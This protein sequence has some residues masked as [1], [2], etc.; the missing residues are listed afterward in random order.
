MSKI[1]KNNGNREARLA[2]SFMALFFWQNA[3][4]DFALNGEMATHDLELRI[5]VDQASPY[6]NWKEG[7]GAFGF[8]VDILTEAAR[9]VGI[10]LRWINCPE[11]PAKALASGKVDL[12]PL[13]AT[14]YGKRLGAYVPA[15]WLQ[16]EYA[17][18]WIRPL[19][20][21]LGQE[22]DWSNQTVSVLNMPQNRASARQYFHRSIFDYTPNRTVAMQHMCLGESAAAFMEIRIM[23]SLLLE[24]PKGCEALSLGVRVLPEIV[25]PMSLVATQPYRAQADVL[26]AQIGQ[27]FLNGRY[28]QLADKWFVF[29]NV[30]ARSMA[31]LL[32][33]R[34]RNR[35]V[36][37]ALGI[38]SIFLCLLLFAVRWA[39]RARHLAEQA[40]RAKSV[41]LANVSHEVRT[42]M[43]GVLG[44]CD[45]LLSTELTPLQR[46]FA[47]TI[48]ES[49]QLQLQ[50]LNDLLDSA[51]IEAG[52]VVLEAIPFSPQHLVEAISR[53]FQADVIKKGLRLTREFV[54][55]PPY[56]IGDPLRVRQIVNNLISN[57]VKF[58]KVG[59]IHIKLE[60]PDGHG[61]RGLTITVSDTG[62][63]IPAASRSKLF[64][65][66]AQVDESNTR[67]FGG[68]G[69]GLHICRGLAELMGGYIT[70]E[71]VE[72]AG[73]AFSVHLPLQSAATA[74]AEQHLA[75]KE[76]AFRS[77]L[78]IL[79]VEDSL[80]NQKV[81]AALLLR[82]GLTCRL[83]NNGEE[84]VVMCQKEHFAA[85]LMDCHM[86]T[87]DGFEA[88]RRIRESGLLHLPIL[89][90]TA[91]TADTERELAIKAGM[92]EVLSKPI[93]RV[94][95]CDALSRWLPVETQDVRNVEANESTTEDT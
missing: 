33:Q 16:N 86:P 2:L 44:M 17:L 88:A 12:W 78:P 21:P 60:G 55:V 77:A 1:L 35:N 39:S 10:Q 69:L 56:M 81:T 31:E 58:T 7:Y 28:R 80:V 42:P 11:G 50:I 6:Q 29:S 62:I 83:A 15:P 19:D 64:A 43:N 53:V 61:K 51:K 37:I 40:N 41:F 89:A 71:S 65:K 66:F 3:E 54:R 30:E 67:R 46:E 82:C 5:G 49:A 68:T 22:P 75:K 26:R 14:D 91:S 90:L 70:V 87:M 36:S 13:L 4:P 24:R 9:S 79:V 94:A 38:M 74:Q 18:V 59:G 32:K 52:K 48:E 27:M 85:I 73:S 84:A 20:T 76:I 63:G 23:E 45:L 92:D 8:T 34:E 93:G 95:L 72:G 47:V 25:T 57:A